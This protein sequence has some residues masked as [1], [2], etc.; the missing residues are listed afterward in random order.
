MPQQAPNH[1]MNHIWKAANKF[2][3]NYTECTHTAS[4]VLW[5]HLNNE[6][7]KKLF[8]I[9]VSYQRVGKKMQYFLT[10]S[11]FWINKAKNSNFVD[12]E[13]FFQ[14]SIVLIFLKHAKGDVTW[15]Q[16]NSKSSKKRLTLKNAMTHPVDFV[17]NQT[18]CFSW[19]VE[20]RVSICH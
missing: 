18:K 10:S 4:F 6:E 1:I 20:K 8:K 3:W 17:K 15:W 9:L 12:S 16:L 5:N 2:C 13:S 11:K 19:Y 7:K 14:G